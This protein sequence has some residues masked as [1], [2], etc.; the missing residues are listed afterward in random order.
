[1]TTAAFKDGI[2]ATDTQMSSEHNGIGRVTKICELPHNWRF[3]ASGETGTCR[4]VAHELSHVLNEENPTLNGPVLLTLENVSSGEFNALLA[5]PDHGCFE[6][7]LM[8]PSGRV[9]TIENQR[10]FT[11]IGSGAHFAMG[12]MAHGA[13]AL[14]AVVIASDYDP[15][16][17]GPFQH[18]PVDD[19]VDTIE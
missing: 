15:F 10:P 12:A 14:Q 16:T 18:T 4:L 7:Y 17:S 5:H 13:T 8:M 19:R 11:A 9:M 1:M 2:L 3:V 6:L